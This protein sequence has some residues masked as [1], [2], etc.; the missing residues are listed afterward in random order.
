MRCHF[1]VSRID[2]FGKRGQRYTKSDKNKWK[3]ILY[4]LLNQYVWKSNKCPPSFLDW[5]SR[6]H[7]LRKPEKWFSTSIHGRCGVATKMK[8]RRWNWLHRV[9]FCRT[10]LW[11]RQKHW[12]K[13]DKITILN[14][15]LCLSRVLLVINTD[16]N[17]HISVLHVNQNNRS[18]F[19]LTPISRSKIAWLTVHN[20]KSANLFFQM[21]EI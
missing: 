16:T 14:S 17:L 8:I 2:R 15:L 3:L 12:I 9:R 7:C 11:D 6:F 20:Y 1:N 13:N 19:R 10:L 4:F 5:S 18:S 21:D